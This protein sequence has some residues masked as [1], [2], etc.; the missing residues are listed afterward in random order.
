MLRSFKQ[1]KNELSPNQ[2][3]SLHGACGGER[4]IDRGEA[5]ITAVRS[6]RE[7][8][9]RNCCRLVC[10]CARSRRCF[11]LTVRLILR[12]W[13]Q[14]MTLIGVQKRIRDFRIAKS[15]RDKAEHPSER[16]STAFA[17]SQCLPE[18]SGKVIHRLMPRLNQATV[19][20]RGLLYDLHHVPPQ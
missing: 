16:K 4:R 8:K 13:Q 9:R 10:V 1:S 2:V 20:N 17:T 15:S 5:L 11:C 19:H 7:P 18:C 3:Q 14:A 6:G 12:Q